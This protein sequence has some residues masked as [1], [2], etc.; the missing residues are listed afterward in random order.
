MRG[1]KAQIS[2]L[3][4]NPLDVATQKLLVP[5]ALSVLRGLRSTLIEEADMPRS[6]LTFRIKGRV[7]VR[8]DLQRD[9]VVISCVTDEGKS[10]NL[11][12]DYRVLDQ[13]HQ[14]IRKLLDV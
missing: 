7:Q 12:A 14:E 8:A 1:V 6:D 11:E 2:E 3:L 5:A 10:L 9:R 13:I 4:H